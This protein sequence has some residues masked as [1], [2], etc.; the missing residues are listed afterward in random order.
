M[1]MDLTLV[2]RR[3]ARNDAA[4]VD[5]GLEGRGRPEVERIDGLHVVVAVDEGRRAVAVAAIAAG[6]DRVA[7]GLGCL[8]V[9]DAE[10]P[11]LADDPVGGGTTVAGMFGQ[12]RDA[13][14]PE[15]LLVPP[16]PV[17]G[18]AGEEALEGLVVAA[19]GR[20]VVR[21]PSSRGMRRS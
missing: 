12:R 14:D 6:D 18:V 9:V 20:G 7:A 5:G 16:H 10:T 2:V 11:Q 21:H 19:R 1:D 15:Q 17:V 13:R 8:R 3:A 4:V